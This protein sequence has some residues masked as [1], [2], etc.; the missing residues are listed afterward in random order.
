MQILLEQVEVLV[1][2]IYI[3]YK[4]VGK[5]YGKKNSLFSI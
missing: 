3:R 4:K 1:Y 2:N 5:R